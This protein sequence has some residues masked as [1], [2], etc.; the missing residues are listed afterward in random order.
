[1][2]KTMIV[3][4]SASAV[5]YAFALYSLL[6]QRMANVSTV[7]VNG[8]VTQVNLWD[9]VNLVPFKTINS[10]IQSY[11]NGLSRGVA[12]NNLLGNFL[13][14]FP[15]GFYIPFFL[16]KTKKLWKF[17]LVIAIIIIGVEVT[18]MLTHTGSLDIDDF[19]L[20][21]AGAVIGYGVFSLPM[22]RGMFALRRKAS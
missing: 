17:S 1:M 15:A 3:I 11:Q 2:R 12:I 13:L 4:I 6:F 21:C 20:N 19:I 22:F 7:D 16:R 8:V 9:N 10:Y 18:Q 5:L 14:F